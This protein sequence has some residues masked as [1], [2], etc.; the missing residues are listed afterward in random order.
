MVLVSLPPHEF[1]LSPCW[2]NF[3]FVRCLISY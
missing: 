1:A 3:F 2:Y